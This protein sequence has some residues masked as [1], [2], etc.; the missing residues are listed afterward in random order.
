MSSAT[1]RLREELDGGVV[2]ADFHMTEQMDD[3]G[4][5]LSDRWEYLLSGGG[6][7]D[8]FYDPFPSS[9]V[10][11]VHILS[12][13][14]QTHHPHAVRTTED[15][16]EGMDLFGS[17]AALVTPGDVMLD[18]AM[19]HHEQLASSLASAYNEFYLTEVADDP[20]YGAIA[21]AGQQP[22]EAAEEIETHA[23]DSAVAA[24]YLPVGGLNPPLGD[25]RYAPIYEACERYDLPLVMHSTASAPMVSFPRQFEGL[26]RAMSNHAIAHPFQQ[27]TNVV[28]MVTNGIPELY[29]VDFVFQEAGLGWVPYF[30]HRLDGEYFAQREDAPLLEK[31]P[32]EYMKEDFYYTSQPMEGLQTA[33]EYVCSV[34]RHMGGPES[35][36]WASDYPH[37]DFDHL[38]AIVRT[39]NKEFSV[40]ELAD[41]FGG[42]ARE[43][44]GA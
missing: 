14:A 6:R 17:D 5:Y 30:M 12:G 22:E 16:Y 32:S 25:R 4:P 27:A 18:L 23:D 28:S 31:P 11:P 39:L 44:F 42:T 26:N 38:D 37:H 20:F 29:D 40:A 10:V 24:A 21:I 8:G 43:V 1:A 33:P 34:A 19:V 35:L 41:V 15:V 13:R 7:F 36:M 2:D 9:G 3:L